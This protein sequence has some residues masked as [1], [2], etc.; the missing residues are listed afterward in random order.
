MTG[1]TD[2]DATKPF[3]GDATQPAT[4]VPDAT[5]PVTRAPAGPPTGRPPQGPIDYDD[6]DDRRSWWPIAAGVLVLGIVVGVGIALL[7][8]GGDDKKSAT[9]TTSSSTTTSSTT[10]TTGP[11]PTSPPT[12]PQAPGQV[13]NVVGEPGGGS[14]EVSLHWDSVPGAATYRIYRTFTQGTTGSLVATVSDPSYVD[15]PGQKAYYQVSAVGSGG[16]EGQR[17]VETCGAPVGEM[18]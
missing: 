1:P 15:V 2:P 18:C 13:T 8:G 9:T 11:P 12:T 3:E 4:R 14:G 10:T 5:E 17:S 7:A 6:D 16:L